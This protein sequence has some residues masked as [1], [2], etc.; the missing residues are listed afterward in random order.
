LI[1]FSDSNF[2]PLVEIALPYRAGISITL[3][4]EPAILTNYINRTMAIIHCPECGKTV[5]DTAAAC[6]GCGAPVARAASERA[7][8]GT[9]VSTIQ[10]TS[11]R[12][13]IHIIGSSLFWWAGVILVVISFN[14][15]TDSS[16]MGVVG[17][18]LLLVGTIWH[19]I[20]KLRVWWHHK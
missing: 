14:A 10:E 2:Y 3:G 18:L 4:K 13:K 7:A 5:S 16:T 9:T 1:D 17:L 20:T 6:P 11:K 12:L 15:T 8:I 19:I